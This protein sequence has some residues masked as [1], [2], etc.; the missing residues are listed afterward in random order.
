MASDADKT[1]DQDI[2]LTVLANNIKAISFQQMRWQVEENHAL[3]RFQSDV[4]FE[5]REKLLEAA[6]QDEASAIRALWETCLQKL[7]LSY[8]L[9]HPEALLNLRLTDINGI[10]DRIKQ[11]GQ[12]GQA[13]PDAESFINTE[14][15]HLLH[16]LLDQVGETL[17]LRSLLHK[18]VNVDVMEQL[19]PL[20]NR[21]LASWLDQGVSAL[22]LRPSEV[23]GQGFYAYWRE[24]T[25]QDMTLTLEGMDDWDDYLRSLHDDPL[26][27]IHQE[28]MRIGIDKQHWGGY[29]RV[30]ALELPGWSG[31]FNWRSKNPG[32]YG[33]TSPRQ[34]G[35]LPRGQVGAGTPVLP[36][37]HQRTLES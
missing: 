33:L 29:L 14:S 32:Y 4:A 8:D 37:I 16:Q 6:G 7:E 19:L 15:R 34:H 3:E 5:Q 21:H 31:M 18:L 25:L 17:T 1:A 11:Q 20:L 28:L 2:Y 12:I 27:T 24:A 10:W 30:L 36:P 9:P 23:E 35:R 26:E 13:I 22:R